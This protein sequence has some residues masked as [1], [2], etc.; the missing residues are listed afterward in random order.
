MEGALALV[1]LRKNVK[2]LEDLIDCSV[3]AP[4]IPPTFDN[5]PV[6]PI[7]NEVLLLIFVIGEVSDQAFKSNGFCPANIS[8]TFQCCQPGIRCQALHLS[9]MVIAIPNYELASEK[10]QALWR[11]TG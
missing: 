1:L 8:L 6:I 2:S 10:A 11:E 9:P 4:P 5:S 7:Y 3:V